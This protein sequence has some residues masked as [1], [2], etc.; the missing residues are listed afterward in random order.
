[1]HSRVYIV[2]APRSTDISNATCL[3]YLDV[4]GALNA[5]VSP[6]VVEERKERKKLQNRLNQR[7]RSTSRL[8]I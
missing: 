2:I 7:A 3:V 4:A 1:M 6:E 8:L 5:M